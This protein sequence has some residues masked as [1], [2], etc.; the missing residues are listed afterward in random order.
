MIYQLNEL[1]PEFDESSCFIA[2][3]ADLIGQVK[4]GKQVSV[5]FQ[6]VIRA[7]NDLV[8]IGD[9][10]NIQDAT[11]IHVDKGHPVTIGQGVTVGHKAML[12]GCSV[13]DNSLIGMGAT[14]LNG[15]KIGKNSI[16]GAGALVTENKSFPDNSLIM[17][18]PAKAVKT[19]TDEQVELLKQ[20]ASHYCDKIEEYKG[21]K[22]IG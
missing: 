18:V 13:A 1:T 14:I 17:G 10:S 21:L 2:P 11:T 7:D 19:L 12:H 20:S 22:V 5:W 9:N 8:S 4:L 15:A 3:S 6:V 16:V